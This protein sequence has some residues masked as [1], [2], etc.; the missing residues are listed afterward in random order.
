[1]RLSVDPLVMVVAPAS[2]AVMA[3][4]PT[5][6]VAATAAAPSVE[7]VALDALVMLNPVTPLVVATKSYT[8]PLT[9]SC[10]NA[11]SLPVESV[12]AEN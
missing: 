6:T 10:N 4:V 2:T 8:T 3:M 1:M 12:N 7:A 11:R 9:L 5:V